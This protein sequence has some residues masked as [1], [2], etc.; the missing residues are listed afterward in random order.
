MKYTDDNFKELL[1]K[2]IESAKGTDWGWD[3]EDEVPYD[4]FDVDSAVENILI[5]IKEHLS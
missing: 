3:G 4:T 1:R 2:A 5:I